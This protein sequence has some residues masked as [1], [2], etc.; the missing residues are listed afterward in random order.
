MK[1]V[2]HGEGAEYEVKGHTRCHVMNK[3]VAGKDNKRLTVGMSHFLPGG[4]AE[5]S[6]APLD[7]VYYVLSGSIKLTGKTEKYV[8]GPGDLILIGAGEERAFEVVGSEPTTILVM[9]VLLD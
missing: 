8:M 9:G 6:S 3:L 2:K 5:M 4:G 7:R 1:L